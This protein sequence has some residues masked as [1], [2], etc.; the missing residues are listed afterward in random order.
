MRFVAFILYHK[1]HTQQYEP[2]N[3][4]RLAK[5]QATMVRFC[6]YDDGAMMMVKNVCQL[7]HQYFAEEILFWVCA[8]LL[9]LWCTCCPACLLSALLR[10]HAAL[11]SLVCCTQKHNGTR[12]WYWYKIQINGEKSR[13]KTYDDD[14]LLEFVFVCSRSCMLQT[15][16]W[17]DS[18]WLCCR[19]EYGEFLCDDILKIKKRENLK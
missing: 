3:R 9:L 15:N 17:A 13:N 7:V 4:L 2:R 8:A 19:G 12:A 5:R 14:D 6:D 10:Q 18:D 16:C 11:V 1:P